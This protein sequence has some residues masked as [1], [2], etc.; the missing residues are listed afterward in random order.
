[1]WDV[2]KHKEVEGTDGGEE[3][4]EEEEREV[5]LAGAWG[6]LQVHQ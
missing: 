2:E 5:D 3:L 1:M 4:E 6:A